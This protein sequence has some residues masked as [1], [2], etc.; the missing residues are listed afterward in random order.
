MLAWLRK[1]LGTPSATDAHP[2]AGREA[3]VGR[4]GFGF[5]VVGEQ[6]YQ[7]ALRR[8]SAGRVERG[9]RVTFACH[10]RYE[11]NPRT[12]G[13]AVR[14]D[15]SAGRTVGHFPAE[16]AAVYAA[17]IHKLE[18]GGEIAV[19]QGVLVGGQPDKPSFGVYLDFKPKL[20]SSHA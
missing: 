14:V 1:L 12:H 18:Q 7:S 11:I 20:L 3:I 15:T 19:C 4:G 13:P 17:A 16:H 9:E 2:N 6:S 10:I 5:E 8:V